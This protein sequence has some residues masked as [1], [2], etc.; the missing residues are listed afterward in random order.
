MVLNFNIHDYDITTMTISVADK[1]FFTDEIEVSVP[2][3]SMV[4][5]RV[6]AA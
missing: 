2:A 4:I 6:R 1:K 5:M 3:E